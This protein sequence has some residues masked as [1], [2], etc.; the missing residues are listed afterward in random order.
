VI[1]LKKYWYY[2]LLGLAVI[3]VI[4]FEVH[5]QNDFD[6]FLWASKDLLKH[7]DIYNVEYNLWYHYYYGILFALIL[8]PFTF[9]PISLVKTIWLFAN[10]FF[11]YRIWR[12]LKGFLPVS[13]LTRPY[14]ILFVCFSFLFMMKFLRDNFHHGQMTI[15]M[16]YLALEG[17]SLIRS[18]KRLAGSLLIALGIDIK[19]LPVIL[20]PYFIYRREWRSVFYIIL[21]LVIIVVLPVLFLGYDYI[22][23]LLKS[24][25]ALLDPFSQRHIVDADETSFHSLSTLIATLCMKTINDPHI[26]PIRRNIFDLTVNQLNIV[27][28]TL[29]L[30]FI[31][32]S[33][34]FLRSWPFRTFSSRIQVLYEIGYLFILVPLLFPHQQ[35]YAY[36]FI[37]PAATY[38]VFVLIY[39]LNM[40]KQKSEVLSQSSEKFLIIM[41]VLIYFLTNCYF[42]LGQFEDFYNHF[43]FLTYGALLLVLVLALYPPKAVGFDHSGRSD[44]NRMG[45]KLP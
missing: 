6:I 36:F 10:V 37:F 20:I 34:W 14:A 4:L 2:Y 38:M 28:N 35:Q 44:D 32:L 33:A 15:C 18:E 19:L 3:T 1:S 43:K 7:K 42:I 5:H 39:H 30:F 8:I 40:K 17:L 21:F 23:I 13:R 24:R 12:I 29:R 41:L 22:V 16:L 11:V 45:G 25:I 9:L 27:I 26:L 31:L